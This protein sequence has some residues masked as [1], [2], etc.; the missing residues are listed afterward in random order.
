[1]PKK[2]KS[3]TVDEQTYNSLV[4]MFKKYQAESSIS[5]FLNYCL[6]QL[7]ENLEIVEKT[8]ENEKDMIVPMKFVID[9][10]VYWMVRNV[11]YDDVEL[12]SYL[13]DLQDDYNADSEGIPRDS[14]PF[15]KTGR[16]RLSPDKKY[17]IE[18]ETGTKYLALGD[19]LARIEDDK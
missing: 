14:Y 19:S 10:M 2:I 5:F 16:Y 3:F 17:I 8:L 12:Y 4:G 9:E 11:P 1:M 18:N 6:T 13:I 15:I 7:K